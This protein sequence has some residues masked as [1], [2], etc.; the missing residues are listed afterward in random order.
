MKECLKLG[1]VI[2][3]NKEKQMENNTVEGMHCL[4]DVG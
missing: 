4:K 2:L 3:V 1:N